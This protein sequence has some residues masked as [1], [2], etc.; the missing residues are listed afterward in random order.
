MKTDAITISTQ[1][2]S[3]WLHIAHGPAGLPLHFEVTGD[4]LLE[5]AAASQQALAV[6]Q[7][8]EGRVKRDRWRLRKVMAVSGQQER[9]RRV[10]NG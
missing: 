3:L 7:R 4:A 9:N 2:G 10:E 6:A 1:A 8:A 5:L